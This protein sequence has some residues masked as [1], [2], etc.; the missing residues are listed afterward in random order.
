MAKNLTLKY[1]FILT[2]ADGIFVG[3]SRSEKEKKFQYLKILVNTQFNKK[4]K[5][6]KHV[7]RL[8]NAVSKFWIIRIHKKCFCECQI[9][10]LCCIKN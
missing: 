1:P 2:S 8:G 3:Q 7:F 10:A 6:I 9:T 5:I 4:N